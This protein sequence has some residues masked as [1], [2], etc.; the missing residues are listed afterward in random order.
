MGMHIQ[1]ILILV[2][3]HVLLSPF[4]GQDALDKTARAFVRENG[5]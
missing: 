3:A 2:G 5:A 1:F 4:A